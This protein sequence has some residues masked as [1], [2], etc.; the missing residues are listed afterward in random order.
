MQASDTNSPTLHELHHQ[1]SNVH[2]K[3]RKSLKGIWQG[4]GFEQ[5]DNLEMAVREARKKQLA[6][7]SGVG[8]GCWGN[9][10]EEI[11]SCIRELR[12]S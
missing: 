5:V 11:D 6:Q 10:P 2:Q 9:T 12:K 4:K 8:R 1:S 3:T 7:F